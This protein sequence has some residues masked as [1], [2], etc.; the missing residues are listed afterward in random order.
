MEITQVGAPLTTVT[1]AAGA[2][3]KEQPRET[4]GSVISKALEEVNQLQ[5]N[6]D[7]LTRQYLTGETT[8]I[9]EVLLAAEKANLALQLTV[10]VRNK[11]IEA[12]Q[13]ISNMQI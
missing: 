7:K 13:E 12:Y 1:G 2:Q 11:I 9:A 10:Q 4:F 8:D 6:A 5:I 3:K